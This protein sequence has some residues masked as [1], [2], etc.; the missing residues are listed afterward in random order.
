MIDRCTAERTGETAVTATDI[1]DPFAGADPDEDPFATS[2]D[3]KS[4]GFIPRPALEDLEGRL[5]VMV[6]RAFMEDAKTPEQFVKMGADPTRQQYTVDLVVLDGGT[7]TYEYKSSEADGNGGTRKVTKVNTVDTLPA[8]FPGLWVSQASLIGQL[9]KVDGTRRPLLLGIM[10]KGPQ[11]DDRKAGKTWQD[12]AAEF[13]AWR[14]NPRG[15]PPKFSWQVDV[16]AV[17]QAH[18]GLASAWLAAARAEGFSI[19]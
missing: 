5:I 19:A 13:A 4:G 1:A 18:K 6:P 10:R 8:L 16:D 11:A 3:V 17:T 12:V 2:E 14:Q 7:L 15:N 9:R